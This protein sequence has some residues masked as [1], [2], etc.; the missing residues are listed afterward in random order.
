MVTKTNILSSLNISGSLIKAIK[1]KFM[2]EKFMV[3]QLNFGNFLKESAFLGQLIRNC[4]M[5]KLFYLADA[6]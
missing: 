3:S 4:K 5:K 6:G 2:I 1:K